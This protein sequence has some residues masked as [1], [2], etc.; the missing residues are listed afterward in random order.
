MIKVSKEN[1]VYTLEN[2]WI[3]T[4]DVPMYKMWTVADM[5]GDTFALSYR[6]AIDRFHDYLEDGEF[7]D[8]MRMYPKSKFVICRIDGSVNKHGEIKRE[9]VYSLSVKQI[10]KLFR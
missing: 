9:K 8:I 6:G 5:F 10:I 7:N 1:P 2:D 4:F 3:G